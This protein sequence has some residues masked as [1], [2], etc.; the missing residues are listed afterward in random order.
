LKTD[1]IK[2]QELVV[3]WYNPRN[4]EVTPTGKLKNS[5]TLTF[6]SPTPGENLDWI[7][8]LDDATK[9]YPAPGSKTWK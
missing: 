3:W 1:A 4:G 6:L 8:I 7:L 2:G 5:G 9:G